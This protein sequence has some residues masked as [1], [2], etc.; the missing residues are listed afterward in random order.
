MLF[1]SWT[2]IEALFRPLPRAKCNFSWWSIN[3]LM[4]ESISSS[5]AKLTPLT[6]AP[7][8]IGRMCFNS[9]DTV[10]EM[11]P[12]VT[13]IFGFASWSWI[14][15]LIAL[16]NVSPDNKSGLLGN[17]SISSNDSVH[18]SISVPSRGKRLER[19]SMS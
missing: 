10:N 17:I 18:E 1:K 9:G 6:T 11:S 19:T 13:S 2:P 14:K 7:R 4:K 16:A 8:I 15:F 12:L 3:D 5:P